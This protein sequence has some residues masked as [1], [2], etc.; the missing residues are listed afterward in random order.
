[1]EKKTAPLLEMRNIKKD[2]AG[3][4]VWKTSLSVHLVHDHHKLIVGHF[5]MGFRQRY[6]IETV[7]PCPD[8]A[9]E[10]FGYK[11]GS[12]L[13]VSPGRYKKRPVHESRFYHGIMPTGGTA[14]A[15]KKCFKFLSGLCFYLVKI[16][17]FP[18][19]G[20]FFLGFQNDACSHFQV[21]WHKIQG[22]SAGVCSI[23]A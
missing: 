17:P 11:H 7:I 20:P 19:Q 8:S 22:K 15:G 10:I 21:I 18:V 14:E 13:Y 9:H 1:M 23:P 6:C 2:F 5:R 4:Q 3:N 12:A 16:T